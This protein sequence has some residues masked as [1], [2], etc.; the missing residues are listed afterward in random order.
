MK[1]LR[2]VFLLGIGISFLVMGA[3]IGFAQEDDDGMAMDA[4]MV[5]RGREVFLANGCTACHGQDAEGN[6]VGPALA[7]HTEFQVRRQVRSPIGIMLVFSPAQVPTEDL[8]TLVAYIHSL[9]SMEMEG[10][11][12]GHDVHEM[13]GIAVGDIVF[14][15]HWLLWL[16]LEAGDI[17]GAIHSTL[18]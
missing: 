8:D 2:Y 13:S 14:G 5:E 3:A 9:E 6:D 7:G 15:H 1:T 16:E 12:A 4:A 17:E 11:E 10:E 18:R